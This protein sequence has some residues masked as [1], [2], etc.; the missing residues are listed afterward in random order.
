[1]VVIITPNGHYRTYNQGVRSVFI[2]TGINTH[3]NN[4]KSSKNNKRYATHEREKNFMLIRQHKGMRVIG[5]V[6]SLI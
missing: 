4:N 6:A 1:M 2:M 3:Y 5:R